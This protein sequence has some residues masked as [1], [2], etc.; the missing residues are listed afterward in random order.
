MRCVVYSGD[1]DVTGEEILQR[2]WQRFHIRLTK[3]VEFVFLTRRNWVEASRY[4]YFTMLGQ[5]FGSVVLGWEALMKYVPDIYIDSMGYAFTIPLFKYLG[6]SRVGCYVHYPTISTD[7]LKKV[8]DGGESHNN[9]SFISR[10]PFI[11]S[12]KI[13]YYRLFAYMYGVVGSRCDVVLVNSSWTLGHISTLWNAEHCT[14]VVYPPCDT[15]EF[16][17]I[18]LKRNNNGLLKITSVAQFRPEKDH[19]LQINSFYQFLKSRNDSE[20]KLY[21][22]VLIGGCR[23]AE[24]TERVTNLKKLCDSLGVS[25]FVEFKTNISF[26]DLKQEMGQSVVGL[27]TMWNEHFGIG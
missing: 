10:S 22:L 9:R 27:H 14:S 2:V 11:S 8:S 25:D 18:P 1:S 17:A 12:V 7:M 3:P 5:S 26:E 19:P 24:D 16:L 20:R 6:E 13:I 21:R 23:N 4:P 15:D